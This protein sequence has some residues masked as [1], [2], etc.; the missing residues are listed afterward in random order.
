[1]V[2]RGAV[3]KRQEDRGGHISG[4]MENPPGCE[5]PAVICTLA[6][7]EVALGGRDP[8]GQIEGFKSEGECIIMQPVR[9]ADLCKSYT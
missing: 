9:G 2:R 4:R 6:E 5:A 1:M 8:T 3:S 7:S